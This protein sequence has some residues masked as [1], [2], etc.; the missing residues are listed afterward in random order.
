MR[1]RQQSSRAIPP[2]VLALTFV[3]GL[4]ALPLNAQDRLGVTLFS[5]R[6]LNGERETFTR[7]E[8]DLADTRFGARRARSADV[9]RGCVAT[10]YALPGFRGPS[11]EIRE[12]DNN[13]ANTRVGANAVSS[14]RIVCP[15]DRPYDDRDGRYRGSTSY[16]PGVTLFR[17]RNL[18]GPSETFD[19]D[20]RD[21]SRTR[22]GARTASSIAV[23]RGCVATLYELPNFRGRK[24]DFRDDDNNLRNTAVGEDEASSLRV[25]CGDDRDDDRYDDRYRRPAGPGV[26]LYRD[27]NLE[28][29][30]ETFTR[31]ERDLSKTSI[32]ART[33]SSLTVPRG[34]VAT[35]YELPFFRGRS[36]EFRDTDNNLKNTTLGN[37][38]A[39]SL[40]IRC[41]G[42]TPYD[43]PYRGRPDELGVTLFRD[44]D[45]E[46]ASE[47]FTTDVPDLSRHPIGAGT[48][49][50]IRVPPGCLAT[51][52]E[53]PYYE[54]RSTTFRDTDN[55][56]KNTQVGN[57][58]ASSIRVRCTR[59]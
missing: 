19:R 35:L 26:T 37:D 28:G 14:L 1:F 29:P 47:T 15:G 8:Y 46:G 32:G 54:G 21:L 40:R 2:F 22:I 9:S 31:D 4:F 12:A 5:E 7:D 6:S 27:I 53:R 24:T 16:G 42:D 51:L 44:K 41:D 23:P 58:T 38:V 34:C 3:A 17:D 25:T 59:P 36:T 55:N 11:V 13:L 56:L 18:S 52:Y 48:A 33:V 50:S 45:L 49:S 57:D 10:L 43:D 39:S 30:S 20:V